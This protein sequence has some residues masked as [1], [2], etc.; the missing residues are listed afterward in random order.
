MIGNPP[1][2]IAKPNSKEFFS[3][4]DPLYRSYGKQDALKKQTGYFATESIEHEWIGYNAGFK[5]SSNFFNFS[6]H[7]SHFDRASFPAFDDNYRVE[8]EASMDIEN[9]VSIDEIK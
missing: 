3:N 9:S 7:E 5:S 1:W 4:I 8:L 6:P 2:D